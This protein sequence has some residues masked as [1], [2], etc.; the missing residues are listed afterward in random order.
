MLLPK[1][2]KLNPHANPNV[3]L[4]GKLL[5]HSEW[6]YVYLPP[7]LKD[8]LVAWAIVCQR[9]RLDLPRNV[10]WLICGWIKT[11]CATYISRLIRWEQPCGLALSPQK[12]QCENCGSTREEWVDE[13]TY[14]RCYDQ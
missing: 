9:M 3:V 14:E 8:E 7:N 12:Q 2:H 10:F 4:E 13:W 6:H 5:V 1:K 11:P